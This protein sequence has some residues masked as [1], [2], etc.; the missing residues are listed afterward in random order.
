MKTCEPSELFGDLA[1][2]GIR[3]NLTDTS[4]SFFLSVGNGARSLLHMERHVFYFEIGL[5]KFNPC[6]I[7]R[8]RYDCSHLLLKNK[9]PPARH[10][11][12][13]RVQTIVPSS[14]A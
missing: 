6:W 12:S 11:E 14:P 4:E 8:E 9:A 1:G 2:L 10:E 3:S 5:W 7:V 13:F